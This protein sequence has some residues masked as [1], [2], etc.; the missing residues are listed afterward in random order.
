MEHGF[1]KGVF[2]FRVT[3]DFL[4]PSRVKGK[5]RLTLPEFSC[6]IEAVKCDEAVISLEY[7][8]LNQIFI[9]QPGY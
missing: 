8:C 5:Q 4:S 7:L 6:M 2:F 1:S 3:M 9:S